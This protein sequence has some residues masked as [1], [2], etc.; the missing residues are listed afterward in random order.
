MLGQLNGFNN[1][2]ANA[3]IGFL[4]QPSRAF[5]NIFGRRPRFR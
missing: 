5:E 4:V 3:D 2:A 1:I